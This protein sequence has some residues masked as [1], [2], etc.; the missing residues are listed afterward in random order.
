MDV[1]RMRGSMQPREVASTWPAAKS[2]LVMNVAPVHLA[3]DTLR[4]GRLEY[5]D[6][7][8]YAALRE[9][10]WR[11]HAFRFDSR[12]GAILNVSL[13]AGTAP[14]GAVE[15][16]PLDKHLLLAAKAIQQRLLLWLAGT[17]LPILKSSGKRLVFLGQVEQ[18]Q[19][20]SKALK[21][22]DLQPIEGLE[23]SVRY[24]LDCRMFID[25]EGDPFLGLV[26]D[27]GTANVIDVPVSELNRRGVPVLDRYV[28]RRREEDRDY[29]R[30]ALEPLG[31]VIS[32]KGSQLLLGDARGNDTVE[33]SEA[34]LEPRT[35]NLHAVI[36]VLCGAKAPQVIS[37]LKNF[38]GPVS[39]A[40]GKFT[41]IERTVE[42]LRKQT[43]TIGEGLQVELGALMCEGSD[44]FP[45]RI[46]THRPTLLFG[47]Q[48]TN[49][50]EI[51]DRG[52]DSWGPYKYM[53]HARNA[54]ILAV[55]CE[56]RYRG[57]VE[58]FLNSLCN[59]IPSQ[60]WK[61]GRRNPFR[62]GLI[63]S[64]R[65]SKPRI[66][67][68]DVAGPS[69]HEYRAAANR[70]LQRLPRIPD[71][72]F[73]QITEASKRLPSREDP[74]LT[75]KAI[76]MASGVVTQSVRIETIESPQY[77][78]A[79]S[80]NGLAYATYAKLDGT[81]WVVSTRGSTTHELVLGI[82]M[83]ET[84]ASRL[85]EVE[86]YIGITTVFHG[87]GRYLV[88]G[89]TREV[90]YEDY[91]DALLESL[92]TAVRYVRDQDDWEPGDK[93]R[94]VFHV[95]KSLKKREIEAT[96]ALVRELLQDAF[97]IE[98]AFLDI[99]PHHP[100]LIF[101]P[102]QLAKEYQ[103]A[104]GNKRRGQGLPDRGTCLHL[105]DHRALL[106]LTGPG[107]IKT[108]EQGLPKPLLVE[109]HRDSD[110]TDLTYLVRQVYH[111]TYASWRSPLPASE[112]VTIAYSR[113]IARL[114]GNL[115][116]VPGWSSTSVTTGTL[117]SRTWFL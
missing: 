76:F 14:L 49:T 9:E 56:A 51:P 116:S 79:Y 10:H 74:Y 66:E 26:I 12:T 111:F 30:P 21:K 109:L 40:K 100:Y 91:P 61:D 65:L 35:E 31:R 85:G 58:Q 1:G 106:H 87:D 81:P 117:R 103:S 11:T 73:V 60:N 75:T 7:V 43:F 6:E 27:I 86:R 13:A 3:T 72:A 114:L 77:S 38:R 96:K 25:P 105:D 90:A 16:L 46:A 102:S 48:G 50:D 54:P 29:V 8:N 34:L 95:Y 41:E 94:L 112:P 93:V 15:D 71:L 101:N 47:A 92:R 68:E 17:K 28:M 80:L 98:F 82:G 97:A 88:W 18:R 89:L 4:V 33:A 52:I 108:E 42:K 55:L 24:E 63:G 39:S 99:S 70:I 37:S 57:R 59:G 64:F 107:E 19:L 110:F 78:L 5:T 20:L 69:A 84:R 113:M 22:A 36:E 32:V 115:K 67:F 44:W 45:E 104:G 83:A 53:Q 62:K 23:V 2:S